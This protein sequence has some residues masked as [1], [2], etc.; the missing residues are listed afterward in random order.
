MIWLYLLTTGSEARRTMV[1][2]LKNGGEGAAVGPMDPEIFHRLPS[3]VGKES[4][5]K[6]G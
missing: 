4:V 1:P 6:S 2:A 3:S 5:S